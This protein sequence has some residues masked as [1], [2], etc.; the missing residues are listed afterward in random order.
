MTRL[1]R[2]SAA[3]LLAA[4]LP[5]CATLTTGTTQAI[6][7]VT[8]PPGASCQLRRDNA[9]IATVS[10]TPGTAQVTK[11]SRDITVNCTRPGHTD[12]GTTL[13]AQFQAMTLGNVLVGGLVGVI[14]DAS[15]GA[16]STYP[17]TITLSLVPIA[18][19]GEQQRIDD[20]IAELRQNCPPRE[21]ARCN[22][23]IRSLE[24]QR[25]QLSAPTS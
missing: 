12:G 20:Q 15:S 1:F 10:N 13:G 21:R 18:G 9:I 11:S 19:G 2:L 4:T 22:Q 14:V 16:T 5:A 23:D 7:V 17:S 25:A 8:D 24:R 3:L 6:T